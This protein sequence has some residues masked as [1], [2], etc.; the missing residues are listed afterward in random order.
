MEFFLK[1]KDTKRAVMIINKEEG[2]MPYL[3]GRIET[4]EKAIEQLTYD[5]KYKMR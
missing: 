2:N 1:I 3:E 4:I 5:V